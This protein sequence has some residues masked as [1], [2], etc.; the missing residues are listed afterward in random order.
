MPSQ[1]AVNAARFA[2]TAYNAFKLGVVQA[3]GVEKT[4]AIQ[5]Q[6][7]EAMGAAHG[8]MLK[9]QLGIEQA[10]AQTAYGIVAQ[11]LD[12]IG[13]TTETLESGPERVAFKCGQC[14]IY[15]A[16]AAMG[17]DAATIEA[18]CRAG[19]LCTMDAIV[20]QLNP[21]L[22]YRLHAFRGG[23]EETCVE[24]IVVV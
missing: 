13:F 18:S 9:T 3:I 24:E 17:L 22:R 1:D 20:R 23:A 6:A 21:R 8:Q 15:E 19:G 7:M 4:L 14:P 11:M 10:D 12:A 5:A 2:Y 16:A